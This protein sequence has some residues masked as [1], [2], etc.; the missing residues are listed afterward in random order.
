MSN[1]IDLSDYAYKHV[2]EAL[3]NLFGVGMTDYNEYHRDNMANII[4]FLMADDEEV[5]FF[6]TTCA[7]KLQLDPNYVELCYYYLNEKDNLWEYGTSPRG[8]WPTN[9]GRE[10]YNKIMKGTYPNE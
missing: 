7:E 6:F 1:N 10:L 2:N 5:G 4:H 3:V 9:A 8:P